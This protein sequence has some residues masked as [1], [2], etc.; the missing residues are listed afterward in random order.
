MNSHKRGVL[1]RIVINIGVE[2][3]LET[4]EESVS[5]ICEL[6]PIN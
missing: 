4:L 5:H 1:E 6:G 3:L 2:V